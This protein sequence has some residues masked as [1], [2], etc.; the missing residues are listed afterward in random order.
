[1][2]MSLLALLFWFLWVISEIKITTY[3]VNVLWASILYIP[4]IIGMLRRQITI[5]KRLAI[6][7][8]VLLFIYSVVSICGV[9]F[10]PSIAIASAFCLTL[11]NVAIVYRS[12]SI[13]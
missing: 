5:V 6:V 7:N 8:I 10:A 4:L 9:Q 13:K 12:R 1:V 3:N 11:R 2:V